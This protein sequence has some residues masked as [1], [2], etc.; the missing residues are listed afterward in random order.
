MKL[1][2]LEPEVAGCLGERTTFD[3]NNRVVYLH[4]EFEGWLGDELLESSPCFIVTES[5]ARSLDENKLSGI[6]FEDVEV[7]TSE[8]FNELHPNR[9]LPSFKRLI[10]QGIVNITAERFFDWSGH[11]FCISPK[12]YLVITEKAFEIMTKHTLRNCDVTELSE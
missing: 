9:T 6:M 5:L 3:E 11:D 8:E 7:S 4:Y 1:L 2:L 10:P 12:N